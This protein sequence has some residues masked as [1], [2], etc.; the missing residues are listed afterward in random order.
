MKKAFGEYRLLAKGD[1]RAGHLW[2]GPDHLLCVE[3]AA[4]LIGFSE[5]YKRIDY[6][7]I[8]AISYARTRTGMWMSIVMIVML[9]L[10]GWGIVG[11]IN[12]ASGASVVLSVIAAP[13]LLALIVHLISGPTCIC[14]LQTAVQFLHLKP[15]KRMKK[16]VKFAAEISPLCQ[17]HQG[18]QALT[19]EA[20]A[21]SVNQGSQTEIRIK[22][23]WTGSNLVTW[24]LLLLV[25]SGIVTIADVFIRNMLLFIIDCIFAVT[26]YVLVIA[27]VVRSM[28]FEIP[29]ALKGSLWGAIVN[30]VLSVVTGYSLVIWATFSSIEKLKSSANA[31]QAFRGDANMA[32]Y[33][34]ISDASFNELG[35]VAWALISIGGLATF[36]GLLGLPSALRPGARMI[37]A[38]TPAPPPPIG[39][40][41]P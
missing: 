28:R 36:F 39:G 34:T 4:F 31:S 24:A 17:A 29:A 1:R 19:P 18:G 25:V 10:L 32:I 22:Q 27:A 16:A 14:K 3:T 2:Q 7:N 35:W 38:P 26:A 6:K 21:A 33:K 12:D 37:D 40:S 41:Q 9:L 23:P 13:V 30:C 8:Q 11:Q 20:L 5:S 15:I